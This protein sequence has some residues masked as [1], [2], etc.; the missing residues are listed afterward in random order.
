MLFDRQA[1]GGDDEEA[2]GLAGG[3]AEPEHLRKCHVIA[4][5][6][7]AETTEDHRE[8]LAWGPESDRLSRQAGLT[9]LG[10]KMTQHVGP[11]VTLA[12]LGAG[13]LV[14]GDL[15]GWHDQRGNRIDERRLARAD[16]AGQQCI[17]TIK[18]EP[19]D[20][21]VE[22]TPVEHLD[23]HSRIPG[24]RVGCSAEV[25]STSRGISFMAPPPEARRDPLYG[26]RRQHTRQAAR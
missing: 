10:L 15:M 21:A 22:G 16:I 3:L 2:L 20:L 17:G 5:I 23:R 9:A 1:G 4:E 14:V 13:G 11:Q 24:S 12:H 7:V 25:G 26:G 6:A 18:V 19:P 8:R